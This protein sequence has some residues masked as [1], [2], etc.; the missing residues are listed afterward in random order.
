MWA[1]THL[2]IFAAVCI[3]FTL[4]QNV[5]YGCSP[6]LLCLYSSSIELLYLPNIELDPSD[7]KAFKSVY[8]CPQVVYS[9][10]GNIDNR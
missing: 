5:M 8:V 3:I 7:A 10:A 9:V 2:Q 1:L 4:S 6:N